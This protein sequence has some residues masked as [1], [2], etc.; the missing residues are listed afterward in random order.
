[1][2]SPFRPASA[3]PINGIL[4]ATAPLNR[5]TSPAR[6]STS[7]EPSRHAR[8]FLP[9][10]AFRGR[11]R[12]GFALTSAGVACGELAEAVGVGAG[13][14][15]G[16]G[17]P[18]VRRNGVVDGDT[19]AAGLGVPGCD[20]ACRTGPSPRTSSRNGRTGRPFRPRAGCR[21]A[22]RSPARPSARRVDRRARRAAH[23]PRHWAALRGP[24][25]RAPRSARR[26][27]SPRA[28]LP[29]R[30]ATEPG[31]SALGAVPP[32]RSGCGVQRACPS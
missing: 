7:Q 19:W 5:M 16:S 9:F 11:G 31:S 6:T 25:E 4:R 27:S 12:R 21:R 14:M 26:R 15:G 8:R 17:K 28:R 32:C 20:G 1:M 18:L 22:M 2:V 3:I 23:G 30:G 10:F 13:L 24:T 29:T